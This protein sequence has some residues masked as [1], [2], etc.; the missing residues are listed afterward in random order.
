MT[1]EIIDLADARALKTPVV[2]GLCR[3]GLSDLFYIGSTFRP[4]RRFQSYANKNAHGNEALLRELAAPFKI[5]VFP[6]ALNDIRAEEARLIE[7]HADRLVNI[8]KRPSDY[9]GRAKGQTASGQFL[10]AYGNRFRG[11][12]ATEY[13]KSVRRALQALSI[14]DRAA[15]E[16]RFAAFVGL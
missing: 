14:D 5:V 13:V 4:A 9:F 7:E 1:M 6:V 15:A 3:T 12:R 11:P 16:K 8:I 2:Y 10:R